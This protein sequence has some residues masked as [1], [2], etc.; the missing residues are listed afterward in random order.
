MKKIIAGLSTTQIIMLSFLLVI[1][2]GSALLFMPVSQAEGVSVSYEDAL[3]TATTS[4]CVTGLVTVTTAS[5]WSA[6]GQAVILVLI[7]VGGLG[8]ITVMTEVLLLFHKKMGMGERKTESH[9]MPN[10]TG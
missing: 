7:Q 8:T 10:N 9:T 4:T 2:A 3:F 1:L 5:S 6:F